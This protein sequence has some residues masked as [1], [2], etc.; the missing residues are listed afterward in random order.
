MASIGILGNM[1]CGKTSV[2]AYFMDHLK[3]TGEKILTGAP[4]GPEKYAT[5]TVDF[6]RFTSKGFLHTLYGTGGHKR[7]ITNYYRKFVLRNADQFL[8]IFDLSEPLEPQLDFFEDFVIPTRQISILLNKYDIASASFANFQD[9]IQSFFKNEK[10]KLIKDI[11]PTVAINYGNESEFKEYNKNCISILL[12]LC[13]IDKSS[14][15]KVW[16]G[17]G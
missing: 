2:F 12:N 15:F 17:Q 5:E 11:L 13:A 9:K 4:G 6:L 16:E 8:C 3:L 1:N 10:K 14:S 7:P